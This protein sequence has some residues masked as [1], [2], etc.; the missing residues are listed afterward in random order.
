M[1]RLWAKRAIHSSGW[2]V[3]TWHVFTMV[4]QCLLMS[5]SKASSRWDTQQTLQC[6]YFLL[7][8]FLIPLSTA[9]V[10]SRAKMSMEWISRI[11][12]SS[13]ISV[14]LPLLD[15][16][17]RWRDRIQVDKLWFNWLTDENPTDP[18]V[19]SIRR[20]PTTSVVDSGYVQHTKDD[21]KRQNRNRGERKGWN[22]IVGVW[23]KRCHS[24]ALFLTVLCVCVCLCLF[25]FPF[26]C[27]TWYLLRWWIL[28]FI[29]LND[30]SKLAVVY[31][32][33]FGVCLLTMRQHA[34]AD[35]YGVTQTGVR[36]DINLF[37]LVSYHLIRWR[38][39]RL[40][41]VEKA[42][43]FSY[44]LFDKWMFVNSITHCGSNSI[45]DYSSKQ[46]LRVP[47]RRAEIKE[48]NFL[49]D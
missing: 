31:F 4:T 3:Y 36:S 8:W 46:L 44:R 34:A 19:N 38:L 11:D 14:T 20:S 32:C 9:F 22:V 42:T 45:T 33:H 21:F 48:T 35:W 24:H 25:W 2:R 43:I 7:S 40:V 26:V 12:L 37:I 41:V 1:G 49:L 18:C 15:S 23:S 29:I 10:S 47:L 16:W 5:S 27:L 17:F 6:L 28:F 30:A 13:A 39:Q